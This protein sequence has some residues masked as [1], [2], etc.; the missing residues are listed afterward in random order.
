MYSETFLKVLQVKPNIKK[1][2]MVEFYSYFS[3]ILY[4]NAC[5]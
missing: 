2:K 3:Y 4:R 5:I 1:R